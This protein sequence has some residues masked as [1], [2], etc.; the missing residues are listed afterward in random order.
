MPAGVARRRSGQA[1]RQRILEAAIVRFSRHS[2]EETGLRDIAA[3]AE[4]DVAFVHRSFGSKERLF[5][6][7][8]KSAFQIED[9]LATEKGELG[10]TL[11]RRILEPS[12]DRALE[13]V[14]PLD[15]V[16]RSLSS[17]RAIPI[18]RRLISKDFIGPL[19]AKLGDA[20]PSRATLVAAC[21]MGI[22]LFRNVLSFAPLRDKSSVGLEPLVASI[23]DLA[24]GAGR[25][26]RRA[27][28]HGRCVQG[29]PERTVPPHG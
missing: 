24:M 28:R 25:H 21:L 9:T 22:S 14:G 10:V 3:D 15:I 17:P 26:T 8:V 1:T 7:A 23:L 2:Y 6:E 29:R 13:L 4:V 20:A 19:T 16:V 18:L 11:A 5:A 12:I 27:R